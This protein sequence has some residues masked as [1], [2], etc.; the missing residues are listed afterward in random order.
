M[1]EGARVN[2]EPTDTLQLAKI[3]PNANKILAL[4]KHFKKYG[5]IRSIWSGGKSACIT[6]ETVEMASVAFKSS[7]AFANNRL[8]RY[9]YCQKSPEKTR[10]KLSQAINMVKVNAVL[11][12]VKTEIEDARKETQQLQDALTKT[13]KMENLAEMLREFKQHQDDLT[14]EAGALVTERDSA[15]EARRAEID[16]KLLAI[17]K[18]MED[19][20]VSIRDIQQMIDRKDA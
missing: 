4:F 17:R 3:P 7:E 10:S 5:R 15:D 11:E 14:I 2:F 18:D 1:N 16:E 12:Q 13:L 9:F 8:V 19:G 20:E 6:Y